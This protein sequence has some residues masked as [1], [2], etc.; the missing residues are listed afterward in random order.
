MDELISWQEI[1]VVIPTLQPQRARELTRLTQD[2]DR[3]RVCATV[4]VDDGTYNLRNNA[5]R[6]LLA[7]ARLRR[8]WVL[9]LQDDVRLAPGFHHLALQALTKA[10]ETFAVV[11]LYS[12]GV[13]GIEV[14]QPGKVALWTETRPNRCRGTQAM[15]IRSGLIRDLVEWIEAMMVGNKYPAG[16]GHDVALAHWTWHRNHQVATCYPSLVQHCALTSTVGHASH[17]SPSYRIAF[18]ER[19]DGYHC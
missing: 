2:L 1:A 18:G 16:D 13:N 6:A 4:F 11:R 15:A 7:G 14:Y 9:M 10:G 12:Y 17:T 19:F 3:E 8:Q 5:N